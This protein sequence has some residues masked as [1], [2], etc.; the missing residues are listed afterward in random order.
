[1][2]VY[3]LGINYID[4]NIYLQ[5]KLHYYTIVIQFYISNYVDI[6]QHLNII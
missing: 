5:Y 1:M 2:E 6:I 3:L 4:K